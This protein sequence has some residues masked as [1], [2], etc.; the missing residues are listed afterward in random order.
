MKNASFKVKIIFL[1]VL[2][3]L[4]ITGC[5]LPGKVNL[6]MKGSDP[7]SP[8]GDL[9]IPLN[10]FSSSYPGDPVS[11][12]TIKYI[13]DQGY[14]T[15]SATKFDI[16]TIDPSQKTNTPLVIYI[17]GGGFTSGDKN[18]NYSSASGYL[19]KGIAFA[20]IN[21]RLLTTTPAADR[22]LLMCLNDAKRCLQF[23]KYYA[24]RLNINPDKIILTGSSAGASASLWMGLQDDMKN[25]GSADP[26]LRQSTRVLTV[27]VSS[28]QSTLD[29]YHWGYYAE[30]HGMYAEGTSNGNYMLLAS[31]MYLGNAGALISKYS[32]LLSSPWAAMRSKLDVFNFISIDDPEVYV[33]NS[34]D[35]ADRLHSYYHVDRFYNEASAKGLKGVFKTPVS[36]KALPST[37]GI[38][39]SLRDFIY[40]KLGL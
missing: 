10:P 35:A 7:V 12:V 2:I 40:R 9:V 33:E 30:F 34:A 3:L 36:V 21:Y 24:S 28:I 13:G 5:S 26:V 37:A 17:H 11:G 20:T 38:D 22:T 31:N 1:F 39:P 23:I 19:K 32:Q 18:E 29:I 14:D 8:S 6:G 27:A 16:F 25:P 4:I 15:F